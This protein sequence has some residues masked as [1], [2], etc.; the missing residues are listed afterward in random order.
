MI[1]ILLRTLIWLP[2]FLIGLILFLL[3]LGLSPWGTAWLLEQGQNRGWYGF[4]SVE[5][6]PL[7]DLV[8]ENLELTSGPVQG[9]IARLKI[10]W[11]KDCVLSGKL[12]LDELDVD[13]ADL[14]LIA[15]DQPAEQEPAQE[16]GAAGGDITLP[17]PIE[18]RDVSLD[19]VSFRL[20]DGT[21][22]AWREFSTGATL[23]NNTFELSPTHWREILVTLPVT[24]GQALTAAPASDASTEKGDSTPETLIAAPI[25][26]S[27]A[28]QSP[29]PA[30]VAPTLET[31]K[32]VPLDERERLELPEVHLPI[33]I[34]APRIAVENL[35][36]KAPADTFVVDRLELALSGHDSTVTI[37][38]LSVSS[39]MADAALVAQVELQG[40]YPLTASFSSEL[41]LPERMPALSGQQMELELTGSLADLNL[42]LETQGPVTANLSATLD[43]LDPTLPFDASLE[44]SSLRWPL[45]GAD[46]QVADEQAK[47]KEA[48]ED[49][50]KENA[51]EG[52]PDSTP[53]EP[54]RVKNLALEAKGSLT[55]YRTSLQLSAS[56]P[57]FDETRLLLEGDGNLSRF[58]WQPLELTTADGGSLTS[59][60]K[61]DWQDALKLETSLTLNGL[62]PGAFTEAVQGNLNGDA[63]LSF[64]QTDAGWRVA[65]PTLDI[66]G[67]LQDLPLSLEA[68]LAGNS[69]MHW[70]VDR[71]LLNQ[72]ENRL[73]AQGQIA[74]RISLNGEIRA[75]A[76]QAIS[77]ELDGV[78]QGDFALGG[79]LKA[80]RIDVDLQGS[81][82]RFADNRLDS[83][84]L[85]ANVEGAE[86][87]KLDITLRIRQ[88]EAAGQRLDSVD[89]TLGGKLSDHR[90]DLNSQA[91]PDM[92]FSRAELVLVGGLNKQR[93]RYQG[94][95]SPMNVD[96]QYGDLRLDD[97]LDFTANLDE[98]SVGVQP[99]CLRRQQGGGLCLTEPLEASAKQG[100]ATLALRQLPMSMFAASV[101]EGW[102]LDG[103]TNG[104]IQ[105]SWSGGG[106]QWQLAS[107]FKSELGLQGTDAYGQPWSLPGS[108]L[109]IE[110]DATQRQAKADLELSL[111]EAGRLLLDTTID[112]PQ[113]IG[114]LSGELRLEDIRLEPY[115]RLI[116]GMEK[117]NGTLGGRVAIGGNLEAP[118]LNGDIRLTGLEA[119]G[120]EVPVEVEDGEINVNLD[121]TQGAIDGYIDGEEGRL[122]LDGSA[123]WP[124]P[125]EWRA[126]IDIDG[127]EDPLLVILPDFG[128]LKIAPD[129]RVQ[130]DPELLKV[131]GQVRIPWA[132]LEVG[133]IPPSAVSPSGDE[134][135]I[136]RED[137]RR[138]AQEAE[139]RRRALEN[140]QAQ[141]GE[142]TSQALAEAGMATDIRIDLVLGPDMQLEAYGLE[143]GLRG[144]LQVRQ[145]NG[146]V[147]LFGDVN[148]EEGR[149]RAYGQDLLIRQGQITFSG[150]AGQP[151][152]QFEAIRNPEKTED[153]VIAGLRVTGPA[154]AP[155]LEIFSEPAMN[156]SRALSYLLRGR[157]PENTGDTGGALTSALI[158]LSIS[159]TGGAV[160]QV[161]QAFG[162]D[163]LTLDT[164]GSGEDSQVVVRGQLTDDL[165]ISY[166]VGVF[167]PIAEL[168]LR[169]SLWRNLYLQAVSGAA[170][171]VDLI[172]SFQLGKPDDE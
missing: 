158:G 138:A 7:D 166:G 116:A 169:Y 159:R 31:A 60:G 161:G 115:R 102:D 88:L 143:S 137:D 18:I 160:S 91:A 126:Q 5:G 97:P 133:K 139:E 33:Q 64:T 98:G 75:P 114:S 94:Q 23:E 87:P 74:E 12:C 110:I 83:L 104:D 157:A 150:P 28:L 142:S 42:R 85:D 117:L 89:L 155:N 65:L 62:D 153:Q 170:Q 107:D 48:K 136:T 165:Q 10:D 127:Q 32:Q 17:F 24:P 106:S 69:D 76:L 122:N 71:L 123:A 1:W 67:E 167:S 26:A 39:P 49:A 90:L 25:D 35:R 45:E 66:D 47:K 92:P 99:F 59:Q 57:Q 54:Y 61:V 145:Q 51:E 96:T 63:R 141:V 109:N 140:G 86:D 37:E 82:L 9:T 73:T 131:R 111:A 119:K 105:A 84:D 163:D 144:N 29:L 147:Q 15:G 38:P 55:G 168:T 13:G 11:A 41:Y 121:G 6:S 112:D 128:R 14:A 134:V 125:S 44:A 20:A 4:E 2:I 53:Q 152:L 154:E 130:V 118:S 129:L 100:K 19:N 70:D 164:A 149:F 124:S 146:P 113:N 21:R 58:A 156:E 16:D 34:E 3:G 120:A 162:V 72:G 171:A 148:L 36:F 135:I 78:L 95:L 52:G 172:Y 43:A 30:S 40:D 56:G 101:P 108:S 103:E 79:T 151:L 93:T 46:T 80:P 132:R 81:D 8:I 22:I 27:I 68:S 50:K 77:P